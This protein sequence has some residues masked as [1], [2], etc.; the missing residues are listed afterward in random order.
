MK[1]EILYFAGC[2]NYQP[3]ADRLKSILRQDGL[4]EAISEIEVKD[5]ETA[6]ALRFFGSP[7]IRINGIDVDPDARN[8]MQIGLACRW[9]P[10]GLPSEGLIRAALQEAMKR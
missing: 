3:T 7:T 6:K 10:G 1:I 5:A 9:Y 4:S 2:P 8:V